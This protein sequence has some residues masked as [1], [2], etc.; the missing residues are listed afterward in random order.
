MPICQPDVWPDDIDDFA[1]MYDLELTTILDQ[2][3]P[4]RQITRRPR[5][6]DPWFDR[7][8]RNAKRL[9]RRFE[10]AY[11]AA[12]KRASMAVIFDSTVAVSSITANDA[13]RTAEIAWRHQRRQYRDLRQR[14]CSS[15]WQSSIEADRDSPRRIWRSVDTLLGRGRPPVSSAVSVDDFNQYF[16]VKVAAVRA[17]TDGASEPSFKSCVEG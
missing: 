11:S 16:I 17:S 3:V 8:N 15:F 12:V 9:T 6:S 10:R 1:G 14:K 2:L 13:V 5:P 7:G 4:F